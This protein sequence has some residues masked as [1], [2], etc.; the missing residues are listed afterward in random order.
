VPYFGPEGTIGQARREE[1]LD[2][3]FRLM[4]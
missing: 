4:P 2:E 3:L 1:G